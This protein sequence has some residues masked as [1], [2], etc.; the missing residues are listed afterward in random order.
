MGERAVARLREVGEVRMLDACDE[1]SL[2]RAVA[3]CDA[4]VVRS[5]ARVCEAVVN[6]GSRL[7]VVGRAGV[8]IEHID[9][10]AA[11]SKGV[12]VVYTPAASTRAVAE[13]VFGLILAVERHLKS[14]DDMVRS[15]RFA[16]ARRGFISR[17][18]RDCTLGVIGMGRIGQSVAR[19]AHDGFGMTIVYND[20]RDV[21]PLPFAGQ[22]LSKEA[23]YAAADVVTLHVPLTDQT[24]GMID[25]AALTKMKT[26]AILVNTARGAV[27]EADALADALRQGGIAGAGIDVFS[28][29]PPPRGHPLLDCPNILLSPHVA[30]RTARSLDAMEDVVDDVIAVLEGREPVFSAV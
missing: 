11:K 16:E 24:R 26:S 27:V 10:A 23:V 25:A 6:A 17:E 5:Y 21:G 12:R 28:P 3:D 20:I 30:S 9:L 1:A 29:E 13:H 15:N 4:L 2:V 19:I 18:L 8:G 14:G 7:R 22:S